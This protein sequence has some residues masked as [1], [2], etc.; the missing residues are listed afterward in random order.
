MAIGGSPPNAVAMMVCGAKLLRNKNGL[1]PAE[2]AKSRGKMEMYEKLLYFKENDDEHV[3]R[4][5]WL[6]KQQEEN[7]SEVATEPDN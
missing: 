1:T 4:L 6:E 2:E 7:M 5:M 3:Q